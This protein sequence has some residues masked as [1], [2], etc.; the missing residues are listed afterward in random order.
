[1][2]LYHITKEKYLT[3]ILIEGLKINSG[4]TGFCKKDAHKIYK[5]NYGVQPIFLTNDIE[6]I[7]KTMLTNG[8]VKKNNAVVL[9]VNVKLNEI[10]SSEGWFKDDKDGVKPKEFRYFLNIEPK[11]IEVLSVNFEKFEL[12]Y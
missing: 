5:S 7:S 1:M 10:N 4:K 3:S 8:W 6:F 2:E 9:K 12:E 11:Q